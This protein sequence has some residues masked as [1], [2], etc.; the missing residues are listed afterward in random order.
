M[1]IENEHT[2]LCEENGIIVKISES[3]R[4]CL[5]MKWK[6]NRNKNRAATAYENNI[7]L[8]YDKSS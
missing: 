1:D 3:E 4:K 2:V 8:V 7:S 6:T 5:I